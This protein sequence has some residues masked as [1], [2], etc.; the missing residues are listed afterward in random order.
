MREHWDLSREGGDTRVTVKTSQLQSPAT[1]QKGL[2]GCD[3][4]W[5]PRSARRRKREPGS[6]PDGSE[7]QGEKSMVL[8]NSMANKLL[9]LGKIKV[10]QQASEVWGWGYWKEPFRKSSVK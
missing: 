2:V 4:A 10:F 3:F 1:I 9:E 5:E 7:I 6:D 8:V